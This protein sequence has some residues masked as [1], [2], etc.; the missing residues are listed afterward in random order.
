MGMARRALIRTPNRLNKSVEYDK[1]SGDRLAVVSSFAASECLRRARKW[2][3][4]IADMRH[5]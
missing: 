4:A 5:N 2:M 1:R 3:E